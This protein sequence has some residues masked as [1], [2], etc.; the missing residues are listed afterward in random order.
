MK[1]AIAGR[2]TPGARPMVNMAQARVAP[3]WPAEMTPSAKPSRTRLQATWMEES[4]LRRSA[5]VGFPPSP[6]PGRRGR[7]GNRYFLDVVAVEL[8]GQD[9]LVADKNDFRLAGLGGMQGA[10]ND[11]VGTEVPT[12]GV[13]GDTR[14]VIQHR[15]P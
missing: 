14:L 8:R 5:S 1:V 9:P 6:P 11:N 13:H 4:F 15:L 10:R 3:E 2:S 12:H 7:C